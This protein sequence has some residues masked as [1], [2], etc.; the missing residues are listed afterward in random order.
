[1]LF[2]LRD[3]HPRHITPWWVLALIGVN[4]AVFLYELS[5]G[6][7]GERLIRAAG[8]IPWEL[9][10]WQDLVGIT[11]EGGQVV[12]QPAALVPLPLT[13]FTAMFL[14]GGWLH[15]I[16]N[17]WY[18]WIFG[19]NIEHLTGGVRFIIFYLVC[20]IAATALQVAV[21]PASTIPM[22]GASGAI[23]GVLGGY[24]RILPHARIHALLFFVFFV[25]YVNVPAYFLLGLWFLMQFFQSGG[26]VAWYAHIGG[27]VAGLVLIPLFRKRAIVE[28]FYAAH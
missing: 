2:P 10:R 7:D 6:K 14:H 11:V 15:L 28:Q 3:D 1:M 19:D 13:A 23:A 16:F 17:M 12:R 24:A 18:L 8:A 20:G 25:R 21:E 5:L 4:V 9:T 22:I 26:G 27:F